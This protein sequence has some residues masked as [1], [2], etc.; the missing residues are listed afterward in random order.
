MLVR[1]IVA[2]VLCEAITEILTSSLIFA[3]LRDRLFGWDKAHPRWVGKLA[4]CGYCVSVWMGL[5]AAF[6]F[7]SPGLL[8]FPWWLECLIFGF[9]IHRASNVLHALLTFIMNVI[10]AIIAWIYPGRP[11]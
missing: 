6:L 10:P 11:K 8:G 5:G 2:V 7:R 3:P 9:V 4:S 1:M